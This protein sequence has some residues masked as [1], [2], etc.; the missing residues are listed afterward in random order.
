MAVRR[1]GAEGALDYATKDVPIPDSS[2]FENCIVS[3][4]R[5]K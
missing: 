5:E 3:T 1:K 2:S 4:G